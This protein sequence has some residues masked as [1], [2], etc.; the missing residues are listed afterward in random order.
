[1]GVV[2]L[3]FRQL[4]R[5]GV[6]QALFI[7]PTISLLGLHPAHPA[8]SAPPPPP[9]ITPLMFR[10]CFAQCRYGLLILA[11]GL[12]LEGPFRSCSDCCVQ[13][14]SLG[15]TTW[16]FLTVCNTIVCLFST[17]GRQMVSWLCNLEVTDDLVGRLEALADRHV[18]YG[19]FPAHCK[20]IQ[21]KIL[22][23]LFCS[24]LKTLAR[25]S[26][27]PPTAHNHQHAMHGGGRSGRR[28]GRP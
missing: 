23:L 19:C 15:T 24:R 18:E 9:L 1:M 20:S 10:Q 2:G 27:F 5:Q 13:I 26:V 22:R 7:A 12:L 28:A 11:R 17:G 21:R 25:A 16:D 6:C 14:V 8:L 3:V 4:W